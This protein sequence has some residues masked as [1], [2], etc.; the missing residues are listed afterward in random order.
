MQTVGFNSS[1]LRHLL[2]LSAVLS[3]GL[4]DDAH[5]LGTNCALP[6]P[7][8]NHLWGHPM[9]RSYS[10]HVGVGAPG[11]RQKLALR[12]NACVADVNWPTGTRLVLVDAP[13]D[14]GVRPPAGQGSDRK[15]VV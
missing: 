14:R 7:R 2:P 3:H 8:P 4:A 12:A 10:S 11:V 1:Q 13:E 5:L 15:S 9:V 6:D